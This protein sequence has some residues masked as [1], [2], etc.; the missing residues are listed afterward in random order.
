MCSCTKSIHRAIAPMSADG[1]AG[2]AGIGKLPDGCCRGF[3]ASAGGGAGVDQLDER[4]SRGPADRVAV[5]ASQVDRG[6][7]LVPEG[8]LL[9]GA[10]FQILEAESDA[11]RAELLAR[12]HDRLFPGLPPAFGKPRRGG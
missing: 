3:A 8:G 4:G 11:T 1:A 7:V 5:L 2:F 10:A 9:E 12:D 6:R